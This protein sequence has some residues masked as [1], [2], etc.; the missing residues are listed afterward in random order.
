LISSALNA[1]GKSNHLTTWLS[2]LDALRLEMAA[3]VPHT[4][5][6]KS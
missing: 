4:K 6:G 5:S 3:E 1:T 2:Q